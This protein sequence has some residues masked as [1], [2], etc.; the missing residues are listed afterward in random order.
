MEVLWEQHLSDTGLFIQKF[1]SI[2]IILF[3]I[4]ASVPCVKAGVISLGRCCIPFGTLK[5]WVALL[6]LKQVWQ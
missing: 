1:I 2:S 3:W 6:P 4:W 5:L